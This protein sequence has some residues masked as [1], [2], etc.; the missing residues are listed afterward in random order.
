MNIPVKLGE[1]RTE[2]EQ[3]YQDVL[4]VLLE[5][6][7]PFILSGTYAIKYYTG[8]DRPTKDIDIFC[9]ASDYP[10]ILERL[11]TQGYEV[12]VCDER[13]LAKVTQGSHFVDIIF[14]SVPGYWPITDDWFNN[15]P[16]GEILGLSVKITPPEELIISKAFR[17][18]RDHFD[19]ADV[20]HIILKKS[21]AINWDRIMTLMDPHWE[22][23]LV[24]L[25]LFRYTYPSERRL[26][27]KKIMRELIDR[28]KSQMEIPAPQDKVSRGM[29]LSPYQY[30][31]AIKEWGYLD[32][33]QYT[34]KEWH[35][36]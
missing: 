2:A 31:I 21:Q 12:E 26:V 18:D 32:I 10:K 16:T 35:Q 22:L 17:M 1:N 15:A 20:T 30:Q 13:W 34:D 3:F 29:V 14:G 36:S 8:I 6:E 33:S 25:L 5:I 7:F 9:K 28:L 11:K 4:K 23:L 19:G 24:H 27:P